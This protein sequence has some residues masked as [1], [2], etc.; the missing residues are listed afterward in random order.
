[1]WI[2]IFWALLGLAA[3]FCARP[4]WKNANA[5]VR[6]AREYEFSNRADGSVWFSTPDAAEKHA[7]RKAAAQSRVTLSW[8]LACAGGGLLIVSLVR[9]LVHFFG[10]E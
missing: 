6:A 10:T 5:G 8:A 2:T 9:L 7:A 4:M 1:M 3:V